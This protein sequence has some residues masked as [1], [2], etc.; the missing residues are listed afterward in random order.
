MA[1]RSLCFAGFCPKAGTGTGTDTGTGT[2]TDTDTGTGTDT[3]T[4]TDTGTGTEYG[5][6]GDHSNGI[7]AFALIA[8]RA[9]LR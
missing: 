7:E 2:G 3:D 1:R 5:C 9:E 8:R 6:R 4:D